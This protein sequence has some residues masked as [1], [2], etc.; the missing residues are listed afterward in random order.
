MVCEN[1]VEQTISLSSK[2]KALVFSYQISRGLAISKTVVASGGCAP[3]P[4]L[5]NIQSFTEHSTSNLRIGISK[6]RKKFDK[7]NRP[8][9]CVNN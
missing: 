5:L 1:H 9:I 2:F 3:R 4:P 7:I 6:M 8:L